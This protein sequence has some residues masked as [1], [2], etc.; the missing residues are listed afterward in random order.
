M[1]CFLFF[2]RSFSLSENTFFAAEIMVYYDIILRFENSVIT[3]F[4]YLKIS[5]FLVSP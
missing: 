4:E 3:P 1:K 5:V 2:K